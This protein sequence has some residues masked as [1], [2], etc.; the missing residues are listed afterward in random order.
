MSDGVYIPCTTG[1]YIPAPVK[2]PEP[3]YEDEDLPDLDHSWEDYDEDGTPGCCANCGWGSAYVLGKYN[4]AREAARIRNTQLRNAW[5]RSLPA[6]EAQMEY[7]ASV[8]APM[9]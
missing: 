1:V 9:A 4:C 5:R 3:V 2:P 7:Y 6:Y 8:I